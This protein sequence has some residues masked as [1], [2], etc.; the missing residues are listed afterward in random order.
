MRVDNGASIWRALSGTKVSGKEFEELY[1][2]QWRPEPPNSLRFLDVSYSEVESASKELANKNSAEGAQPK[3]QAY[4]PPKARG[5]GTNTVAAMM[6]GEVAAPDADDRRRKP[7][8]QRPRDDDLQSSPRPDVPWGEQD[9]RDR[10]EKAAHE[11]VA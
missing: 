11:K 9:H 4:R 3:R 1:D 2:T 6:R 10:K 8:Q 7:R 5:E